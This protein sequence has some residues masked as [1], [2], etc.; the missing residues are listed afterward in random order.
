[1]SDGF[2]FTLHNP[3]SKEDWDKLTDVELEK[4][5]HIWFETPSGKRVDYISTNVLNKI[6]AEIEKEKHIG[7]TTQDF[8]DGLDLAL[9]IIDKHMAERRL[10]YVRD[11]R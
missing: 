4:T 9:E 10:N 8:A 11:S 6:R 2:E 5:D 7:F 3:L 1:M